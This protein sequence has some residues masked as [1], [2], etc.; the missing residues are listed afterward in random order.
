MF[1]VCP[2]RWTKDREEAFGFD[3]GTRAIQAVLTEHLEDAEL[4]YDFPNPIFNHVIPLT[5]F[6]DGVHVEA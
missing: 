4:V 6:T 2:D 5:S 3:Q 1:Y